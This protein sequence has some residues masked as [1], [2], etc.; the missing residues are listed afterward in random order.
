MQGKTKDDSSENIV[1]SS[2]T[3]AGGGGRSG[4]TGAGEKD[5]IDTTY[6]SKENRY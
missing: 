2:E 4:V 1:N 6:K 3:K 5:W